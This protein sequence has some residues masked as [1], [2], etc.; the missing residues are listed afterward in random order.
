MSLIDSSACKWQASGIVSVVEVGVD[1]GSRVGLDVGFGVVVGG[2]VEVGMNVGALGN[3]TSVLSAQAKRVVSNIT[4]TANLYFDF[5]AIET[6]RLLVHMS[7]MA[8]NG[9]AQPQ[10]RVCP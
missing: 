5:I 7:T 10:R 1:V 8:A 2:T 6:L 4:I 3:V 9:K